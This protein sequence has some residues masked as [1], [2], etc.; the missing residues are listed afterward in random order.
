MSKITSKRAFCYCNGDFIFVKGDIWCSILRFVI[1]KIDLS[2]RSNNYDIGKALTE[3]LENSKELLNDEWDAI[4]GTDDQAFI[5]LFRI[6]NEKED[7]I[8]LQKYGYKNRNALYKNMMDCPIDIEG[9]VVTI[10]IYNHTKLDTWEGTDENFKISL[11]SPPAIIGATV[12]Y[13]F[14]RCNGKG[15]YAKGAD[16]VSKAL[17]PGGVPNSLEEYLKSIDNDYKKWLCGD[18]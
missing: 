9:S 5:D 8:L 16:I 1:S 3:C 14:S 13:A 12:R 15:P 10:S 18:K 7:N 4:Y 11:L 6:E 17:F 2:I